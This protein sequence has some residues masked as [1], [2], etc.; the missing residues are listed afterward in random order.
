MDCC[1]INLENFP[2]NEDINTGLV[3]VQDGVHE[4]KFNAMNFTVLSY[5]KT[6]GI[7]DP[8]IIPQGLLSED[9][10]YKFTIKQPDATNFETTVDSVTCDTFVLRTYIST[11]TLCD[12]YI[13]D[14]Q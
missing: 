7:G 6:F 12:D 2:H 4:F 5:K 13:C 10:T 11:N 8:I 14:N 1:K 9:F 3:A